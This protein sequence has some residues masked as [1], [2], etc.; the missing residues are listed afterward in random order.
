M[1]ITLWQYYVDLATRISDTALAD[2]ETLSDWQGRR[3]QTRR[4]FFVSMG[5]AELPERCDLCLTGHGEFS[6]KGYR[7]RKVAYQILPDCWGTANLYLPDPLPAGRL[8]AVHYACGHHDVG[9]WGYQDHGAMWARR[10]YACFVFDTI[11][12]HDNPGEHHGI[13]YKDRYD[14]I[15]M[16]Y[17]AAGGELWNSIRA[18][19]AMAVIDEIDMDRVGATGN[20]G[21]GALSFLLGVADERVK[22]VATS[23]GVTTPKYTIAN[24][25]FMGHCDCIYPHNPYQRD[26]SEFAALIAPRPLLYCFARHDSLFNPDEFR[27][28]AARTKRIYE[29]HGRGD[30]CQLC[31]YDGP[32]GYQ[33]VSIDAINTWFDTYVDGEPHPMLQRGDRE[34]GERVTTVFNGKPPTPDRL[35][36]LPELISRTGHVRLPDA[37]D[38]WPGIRDAAIRRLRTEV[39]HLLD[40]VQPARLEQ[41]GDWQ[42]GPEP[43]NRKHSFRSSID[44][45]DI[46]IDAHTR[47]T[48]DGKV[49][50]AL[51]D[52]AETA[53]NAGM[54]L[55]ETD[56][57]HTLVCIESRGTGF[58]ACTDQEYHLLRAGA[59]TGVTPAALLV[60]DLH[61]LMPLIYELPF[62]KGREVYLCGSGDAG[63]ACLYHAL[64][65][66]RITGVV[67]ANLPASHRRGGYIL[68]ILRVLDL[69]QAIG[70]MAPR[71]IALVDMAPTRSIHWASRVYNRLNVPGRLSMVTGSPRVALDAVTSHAGPAE[72]Q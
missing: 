14:W 45:M 2:V 31:E 17:T 53:R 3:E 47:G 1:G 30:L 29:L 58:S 23:C 60:H 16:G 28:L 12:Q 56:Y 62:V 5:L 51:A 65:D 15:S 22:A 63:I 49:I 33:P 66:P 8:P 67:A 36:L 71:P 34:H 21:G 25:N 26:T 54:R 43:T 61:A 72:L 19:D 69:P 57:R 39:F 37:D 11:E 7:A 13:Y 6:G 59:L 27:S 35:D 44:H 38:E 41:V 48:D 9:V 55:A 10:G 40:H 70:L 68:G 32:H 20:S 50:V 64:L 18:L 42:N 24:R 52:H 4:E 46:W